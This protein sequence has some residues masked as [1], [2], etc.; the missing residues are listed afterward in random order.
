MGIDVEMVSGLSRDT[1]LSEVTISLA[2]EEKGS[3]TEIA[4]LGGIACSPH[5]K[6]LGSQKYSRMG[7]WSREEVGSA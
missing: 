2:N 4:G 5:W 3:S 7:T 6:F 1:E